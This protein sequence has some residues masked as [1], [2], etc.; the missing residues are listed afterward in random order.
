MTSEPEGPELDH[1]CAAPAIGANGAATRGTTVYTT[2]C[3]RCHGANG[4]TIRFAGDSVGELVRKKP[5][6]AWFKVKFGQISGPSAVAMQPARVS[7]TQ[8]LAD[9]NK[10]LANPMAY[11]DLP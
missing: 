9:L 7:D 11:P 8:D 2:T 10:A 6:E 5:N 3:T 1:P 4:T